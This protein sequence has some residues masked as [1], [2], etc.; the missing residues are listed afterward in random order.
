[1]YLDRLKHNHFNQNNDRGRHFELSYV[2]ATSKVRVHSHV[3]FSQS[4]EST[5]IFC[6][7]YSLRYLSTF[8]TVVIAL[9]LF[10]SSSFVSGLNFSLFGLRNHQRWGKAYVHASYVL[11][12]LRNIALLNFHRVYIF[13]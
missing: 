10:K 11:C 2:F 6:L 12:L 1:M 3:R 4:L 9:G 8:E 7:Q 13:L 5:K